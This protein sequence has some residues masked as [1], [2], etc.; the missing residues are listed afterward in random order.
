[1][2]V[3]NNCLICYSNLLLVFIGTADD[4]Q[5]VLSE[6]LV[7]IIP[8]YFYYKIDK[9]ELDQRVQNSYIVND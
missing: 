7:K 3:E 9:A 4:F 2:W 1:M 5:A 6:I 8:K